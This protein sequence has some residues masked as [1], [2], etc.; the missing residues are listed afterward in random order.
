MT[1]SFDSFLTSRITAL[2][3]W[4]I[5]ELGHPHKHT[6][7]EYLEI[8]QN[9]FAK[10]CVTIKAQRAALS[11]GEYQHK[12]KTIESFVRENFANMNQS[13]SDVVTGL[14]G[15]MPFGHM[16][17]EIGFKRKRT[18]RKVEYHLE[19]F[20]ILDP[21]RTYYA[22]HV[23]KLTHVKY[24]DRVREVWVPYDKCIHITNNLVL[25]F[26]RYFAY[27]SPECEVA[28][29][30]V[31]L[32]NIIM[33]ECAISAKTL[34]TGII[35]GRA[36]S[37]NTVMAVDQWGKQV[38]D[39]SGRPIKKDAVLALAEQIRELEN[40]AYLVT[41][42]RNE[43][44]AL[45]VP[46][47]EQFWSVVESILRRQIFVA[48]NVPSMVLDEGSGSMATATLSVKHMT[49]LDATVEAVVNQIRDQLI[50]KVC[51]NLIIWNFGQQEDY[52][53]F[54]VEASSDPNSDSMI[55]QSLMSAISMGIFDKTD[56]TVMNSLRDRLKLPPTTIEQMQ[57]QQDLQ[58][59]MQQMQPQ[60]EAN[61]QPEEMQQQYP[62]Q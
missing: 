1:T 6:M 57:N 27:G 43:V 36:D 26:N 21:E 30:Y 18:F 55:A 34:A 58:N 45:Q 4:F 32:Y 52:G 24:F 56:L 61:P 42:K 60:P 2:T 41:D 59:A 20:N 33:Q 28:Y 49:I 40:H 12:D 15:A 51:R 46:A 37:D 38:L 54:N 53:N 16:T 14:C 44:T 48:F 62:V 35:V 50:Q 39:S 17:A 5:Q 8:L 13:L 29:P 3:T 23:G 22:G 10:A 31:K 25:N 9:P 47:G 19:G 11:L 7:R